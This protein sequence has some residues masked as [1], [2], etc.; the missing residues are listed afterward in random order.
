V[1][2][3]LAWGVQIKNLILCEGRKPDDDN[4]SHTSETTPFND[5]N[6]YN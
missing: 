1:Q 6:F 4:E 5:K 2:P 3:S